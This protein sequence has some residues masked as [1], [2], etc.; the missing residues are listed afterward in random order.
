MTRLFSNSSSKISKKSIF[1][2][3]FK[4]FYFEPN[5]PIKGHLDQNSV[6]GPLVAGLK[7]VVAA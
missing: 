4:D 7:S 1:G 3:K 5:F 2:P 6:G